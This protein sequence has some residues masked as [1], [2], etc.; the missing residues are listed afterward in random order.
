MTKKE[1]L[2]EIFDSFVKHSIFKNKFSLQISYTPT[3]ILHRE[4]QIKQLARI[5]APSLRLEKPSN[6]FLYGLTGTGKTVCAQYVR[7]KLLEK[8]KEQNVSLLIPYVNCKLRKVA[9][10]EY[11]I[12][13]ELVRTL[14]G[15]V[16]A[17][18]LPTEQIYRKFTELVDIEKQIVIVILDEIDRAVSK[19]GD[20]FLYN[21]TR[22]N[23]ELSKAQISFVGI[24]NNLKFLDTLDPRV[25]SSL[26][27]EEMLFPPY[28]ALQLQDILR[29]RAK[30][31]FKENVIEEGVIE[32]CAAYAAREHGDA[33][34]A[35]DL[36]R[37]AGELVE[38][39]GKDKIT[40]EYIDMAKE[41]IETDKVIE[42]IETQPRHFQLA[43]L[44][45]IQLSKTQT[46][47]Y[48]GDIY[49][50]Y[51]KFCKKIGMNCLTQRRISDVIAELDMLGL[52][53]AKVISKGRYGRTRE[54]RVDMPESLTEKV[55]SILRESL[56]L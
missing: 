50:L 5:L 49:N 11:R 25:K 31:A 52:I 8:A 41:K 30:E 27:E 39:D 1:S 40:L 19:I 13:A 16:P 54:I 48:T 56:N 29:E 23:T 32:K 9:D 17:T 12:L 51:K 15:K 3:T 21:L 20:E 38:R 24:S 34:R 14:G 2:D 37:I 53:N 46:K 7:K 4:K 55:V 10:T 47:I 28:N 44:A 22:L 18:G 33:R 45:T 36:L 43:L 26:S 42:A 35:L 6:V